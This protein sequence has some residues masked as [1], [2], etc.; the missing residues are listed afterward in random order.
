MVS[1][2]DEEVTTI[3]VELGTE[4]FSEESPVATS[5]VDDPIQMLV[6]DRVVPLPNGSIAIDHPDNIKFIEKRFPNANNYGWEKPCPETMQRYREYNIKAL[7]STP[8]RMTVTPTNDPVPKELSKNY[9][10]AAHK[11][12]EELR[13]FMCS[14]AHT[15]LDKEKANGLIAKCGGDGF[16]FLEL[17]RADI[18]KIK[19]SDVA[20]ACALRDK[21]FSREATDEFRKMPTTGSCFTSAHSSPLARGQRGIVPAC[22]A[23][24][25]GVIGPGRRSAFW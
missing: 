23:W 2:S 9:I 14:L 11:I 19:P 6:E 17:W 10:A 18:A 25:N 15:F 1:T 5:Y 3:C 12:K 8:A 22:C 13:S 21:F 24:R 7:S 20:L 16:K 4:S